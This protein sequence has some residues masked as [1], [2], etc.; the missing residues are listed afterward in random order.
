MDVSA[1]WREYPTYLASRPDAA[2]VEAIRLMIDLSRRY[3][4]RVHIVHL[5]SVEALPI[6]RE[7]R[8][9]GVTITVETCPHY[10]HFTAEEIADGATA[11]KCAPP[12]RSAENR[13]QLWQA[14]ID[15][16]IDLVATDHSPCPPEMKTRANGSFLEAWGG[17]ASLQLALPV[18]WTDARR[19]GLSIWRVAQWMSEQPASL[20]GLSRRKGGIREGADAD[21]VVFDAGAKFTVDP[22]RLFHRHPITPYADE[23]LE[24]VVTATWVRGEKV[25]DRG[26]FSNPPGGAQCYRD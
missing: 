14:L 6:L 26:E 3:G 17:I 7:A 12:I 24:G 2:E 15:G 21:C 4:C 10:L 20:A 25:Y 13:E 1:D 19:R 11:F 9:E 16:T 23:T 5:S 8:A 22:T 18:I